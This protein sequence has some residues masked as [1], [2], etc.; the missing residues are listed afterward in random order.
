M[1]A[2]CGLDRDAREAVYA[3]FCRESRHGLWLRLLEPVDL[4][5]Q[6]EDRKRHYQ[7]VQDGVDEHSIIERGGT[8]FL[9]LFQGSV[10]AS[11][12]IEKQAAEI[13]HSQ[14]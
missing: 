7:K 12:K 13:H 8:G 10:G 1:R 4:P 6:Q 11:R 2:P 9:R 14:R 3:I 5:D